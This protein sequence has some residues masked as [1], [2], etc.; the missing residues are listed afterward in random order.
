MTWRLHHRPFRRNGE[1]AAE[2]SAPTSRPDRNRQCVRKSHQPGPVGNL[3]TSQ[4]QQRRIMGSTEN[5]APAGWMPE[6]DV[7]ATNAT[8]TP[9]GIHGES[10]SQIE[11]PTTADDKGLLFAL[12]AEDIVIV[13]NR[14]T[15]RPT[16]LKSPGEM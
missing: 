1:R 4:I 16:P 3:R 2:C 8:A 12:A 7:S 5:P 13:R 10:A 6:S 11:P 14:T 15:G 9:I